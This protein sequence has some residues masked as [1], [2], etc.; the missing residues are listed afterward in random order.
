MKRDLFVF[1][2]Q[3]NMMGA[4]VFAPQEAV[5][6]SRSFEYKH[7]ER[8][9]G[10]AQGRFTSSVYPAG[11]FSYTDLETAYSAEMSD[12]N[13]NSKR[14]D[15]INSAYFCP[16]MSNLRSEKEKTL[17]SFS[18]FSEST[19]QDGATLAPLLAQQW[20]RLGGASAYA[21]IAKGCVCIQ[22]YFTEQMVE[23]Y[24]RRIGHY[25]EVHG[26]GFDEQISVSSRMAGAAEYFFEKSKHFFEDAE[27][28][29]GKELSGNRCFFWLQG[30]GDAWR[31]VI[32]YEIKLDILWET[33]K[34]NGFTHFFCIRVGY[35][36]AE[37]IYRVMQAQER[38]VSRHRD[39]YMLTRA[40]SYFTYPKQNEEDWFITPPSEEYRDC[41]DSFSGYENNH[42]NEKGFALIAER[43]AQ[44]LYRVLRQ[45]KEPIL[46]E[47]NIKLLLKEK[48]D[49]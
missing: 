25:N 28:R 18:D 46:E 2:G 45:N 5:S 39:A 17:Y 36:G 7:K 27:A 35:F 24:A 33:L 9:L 16:A 20:E 3:S 15:Y 21:H 37:G 40:A 19:A 12:E 31:S 6:L 8:R 38:F 30:E 47:E 41:R 13:G 48:N 26:T 10:A 14:A 34:K 29:F 22:Y 49:V 11:E 23:E 44:N 43:C 1:A 32:E 4:S 42:I